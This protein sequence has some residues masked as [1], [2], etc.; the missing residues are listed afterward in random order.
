MKMLDLSTEEAK[1][2]QLPGSDT[3]RHA[4]IL[5]LDDFHRD[6]SVIALNREA[7]K[8]FSDTILIQNRAELM[9]EHEDVKE[10]IKQGGFNS[11]LPLPW[12]EAGM[13]R[14]EYRNYENLKIAS[15]FEL[16][17]KTKLISQDYVVHCIDGNDSKYQSLAKEQKK[18]PIKKAELFSIDNFRFNGDENYLPGLTS[19]SIGFEQLTN[20]DGYSNV[21]GLPVE[22]MEIIKD[23]RELRNQ[24]HLPVGTIET[25]GLQN[26]RGKDI[27][28]VILDFVNVNIVDWSN[29]LI[30]NHKFTFPLLANL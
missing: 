12:S 6:W 21:I 26:L 7:Y 25:P 27:L 22:T 28:E 3:F 29:S 11:D 14:M 9:V 18:R 24:I 15:G 8:A 23:Y 30:V 10:Y 20:R 17:L 1:N 19:K 4:H 5:Y 13:R 2:R 16:H